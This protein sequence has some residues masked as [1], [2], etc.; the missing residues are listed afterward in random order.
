MR[1]R[2]A[3]RKLGRTTSHRRALRRNL[4]HSLIEHGEIRTT[5]PKAKELRRFVEKLIT[6]A[7][8]AQNGDLVARRQIHKHLSDRSIIPKEHL[9][10][11]EMMSDTKRERVVRSLSGRRHRTGQPKGAL[12]FTGES[13]TRRLI[14]TIA[15]RYTE[16]RGGY[17]R[18]VRLPGWRIG[19]AGEQA[20]IQLV[21]DETPPANLVRPEKLARRTRADARYALA[22]KL[23]KEGKRAQGRGPGAGAAAREGPQPEG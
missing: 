19:D 14:E 16:R 12:A 22:I 15:P 5:L 17:T 21:G 11:Y 7:K 3:H 23:A 18:I 13:V 8:R 1:H 6:L 9:S 10:D 2:I 4:A 20:V